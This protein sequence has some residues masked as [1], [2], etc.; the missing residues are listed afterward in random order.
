MIIVMHNITVV[1]FEYIEITFEK[2][3]YKRIKCTD[4][5]LR[6]SAL[7]KYIQVLEE[8]K[9]QAKGID[10]YQWNMGETDNA[11]MEQFWDWDK[12]EDI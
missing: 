7:K 10:G 6:V 3:V 8:C 2:N 11:N 1:V 5:I 12:V 4:C 9:E